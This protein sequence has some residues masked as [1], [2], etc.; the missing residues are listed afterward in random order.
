MSGPDI[1][2][3]LYIG[4][5]RPWWQQWAAST[6]SSGVQNVGMPPG[7]ETEEYWKKHFII[8]EA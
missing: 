2:L 3:L 4:L 5:K 7:I 1:F 8:N 6:S